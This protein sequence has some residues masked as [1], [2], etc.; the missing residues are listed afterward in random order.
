MIIVFIILL[1][2]S[3]FIIIKGLTLRSQ[4]NRNIDYFDKL[5]KETK[6]NEKYYYNGIANSYRLHQIAP[7]MNGY[8]TMI[9]LDELE[10]DL[11]DLQ[12]LAKHKRIIPWG[13]EDE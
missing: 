6:G 2:I 7:A 13:G 9:I 1:I 10:K 5:A 11:R 12:K 4:T 8:W 3:F